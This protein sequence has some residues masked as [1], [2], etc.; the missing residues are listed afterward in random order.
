[1]VIKPSDESL[2]MQP[3]ITIIL[4]IY[5]VEPYLRQC[6][7]S[8]VNQTMQDIQIICV[9]D[10]STD[11]SPAILQEY[12]DKDSRI[13]IVHQENQGGGSARNAAY[14]YIKGEYTYFADPDDWLDLTLCEKMF[15][16]AE[17]N[18]ADLVF[19]SG[20]HTIG[21]AFKKYPSCFEPEFFNIR[22]GASQKFD[23]LRMFHAPWWKLIKSELL[24]ASDIRFS[25]GKRPH[26]DLLAHWKSV[27]KATKIAILDDSLY[28]RRFRQNSYQNTFNKSRY[29]VIDTMAEIE[30]MLHETGYYETYKKLFFIDK[31][32]RYRYIYS[33][34]PFVLKSPFLQ[35]V[36]QSLTEEDLALFRITT[37]AGLMSKRLMLF[38]KMID[39]DLMFI[40]HYYLSGAISLP[41]R[42]LRRWVIKPIKNRLKAA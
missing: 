23:L 1:M 15:A 14:P 17:N 12:A 31:F 9:N 38:Y 36:R 26:N 39:G 25:E 22:Q 10:G 3:K 30:K 24:L 41:E 40:L 37:D 34:L 28:Y 21:T 5:N 7:D 32:T 29:I 19:F 42:L 4:P 11:G 2:I 18:E 27:V 16:A 33:G 6:L 13:E 20:V 8:V 35:Y